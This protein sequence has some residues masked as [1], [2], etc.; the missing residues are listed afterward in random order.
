MATYLDFEHKIKFIQEDIISAQ[1]R[2]DHAE[3]ESLK[4][5]LAKEV[6]KFRADIGIALDGDA[7]RLVVVDEKGNIKFEKYTSTAGRFMLANIL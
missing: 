6:K 7:D 2:H 1:V 3:V 5:T 4:E